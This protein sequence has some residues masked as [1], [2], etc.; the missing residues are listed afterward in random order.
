MLGITSD[1]RRGRRRW[2]PRPPRREQRSGSGDAQGCAHACH[3]RAR[4]RTSTGRRSARMAIELASVRILRLLSAFLECGGRCCWQRSWWAWRRRHTTSSRMAPWYAFLADNHHHRNSASRRDSFS[5]GLPGAHCRH[6]SL[7]SQG[8]GRTDSTAGCVSDRVF[9][10]HSLAT[11]QPSQR[12]SP[13]P[14]RPEAE[15]SSCLTY[16]LCGLTGRSVC[17]RCVL[18]PQLCCLHI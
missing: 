18:L 6:I 9:P 17:M 13:L 11:L 8:D 7:S 16:A 4:R 2:L 10:R 5:A 3:V 12:P 14:A 15:P 1:A